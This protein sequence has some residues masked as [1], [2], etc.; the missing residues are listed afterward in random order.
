MK[1]FKFLFILS[2]IFILGCENPLDSSGSGKSVID[3]N[4]TAFLN[5][6][7]IFSF[8]NH[9]LQDDQ[10]ILYFSNSIGADYYQISYGTSSGNYS[11][12]VRCSSSPCTITGLT[13]GTMYYFMASAINVKGTRNANSEISFLVDSCIGDRLTNSPFA[14]GTGTVGD[15]YGI[16]TRDQLL[17][18]NSYLTSNFILMK[19]INLNSDVFTYGVI[20]GAFT[21]NFNGNNLQ[22]SN[23]TLLLNDGYD[24]LGFFTQASGIISNLT[25]SSVTVDSS[26]EGGPTGIGGLVG[27]LTGGGSISNSHISNMNFTFECSY[28]G[29][30]VG[31][32]NGASSISSSSVE[33][34]TMTS[35][36]SCSSSRFGGLVG[37]S[38]NNSSTISNSHVTGSMTV[39]NTATTY[40]GGLA[41]LATNVS[42]SYSNI[43]LSATNNAG[44]LIGYNLSGTISNN[45]SLGS[46]TSTA[47]IAGG[48]VAVKN[49]T[50]LIENNYT[51]GN[52]QGATSAGGLIGSSGS[53]TVII[54]N[55]YALGSISGTTNAGGLIGSVSANGGSV[56][57]SYFGGIVASGTNKGGIIGN[58]NNAGAIRWSYSNNYFDSTKNAINADGTNVST[59]PGTGSSTAV[60]KTAP[61]SIYTSWDFSTIWTQTDGS[62]PL[63]R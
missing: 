19:N 60:M 59:T 11:T 17:N 29:G 15:P 31:Q 20:V 24:K 57:N 6:P 54:R 51:T 14:F 13:N 35:N 1:I 26:N 23:F 58:D 32:T 9:S 43:T 3:S 55:S 2:S 45:Y 33:N 27:Y 47:G 25:L 41:G 12:N 56:Q 7:G 49:T 5:K 37:M 10:T 39:I 34:I 46:T 62:Y 8:T 53:T 52:V 38:P 28:A 30:L 16:C 42:N 61:T 4:Y 40:V 50:G 44:G 36:T 21:G 63:L 48:L 22:I 18:V